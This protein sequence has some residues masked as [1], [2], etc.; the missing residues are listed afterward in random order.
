MFRVSLLSRGLQATVYGRSD[1]RLV[2]TLK[3]PAQGRPRPAGPFGSQLE[4]A[5]GQAAHLEQHPAV[6]EAVDFDLAVGARLVA[7]GNLD[8]LEVQLGRPESRAHS[9]SL[10]LRSCRFS[11]VT[12][13][14]A[15]RLPIGKPD[16]LPDPA[17]FEP[18]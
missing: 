14:I 9:A 3:G 10:E 13:L 5:E 17:G 1:L 15:C 11:P 16:A 12:I 2:R 4:L 18:K 6:T 7:D 8:N